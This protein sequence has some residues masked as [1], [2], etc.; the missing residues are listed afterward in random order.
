MVQL[1]KKILLTCLLTD[2]FHDV[3]TVKWGYGCEL[4]VEWIYENSIIHLNY[5][6]LAYSNSSV[7]FKYYDFWVDESHPTLWSPPPQN[8]T[9]AI[10]ESFA[11]NFTLLWGPVDQQHHLVYHLAAL[12]ENSNAT[13]HLWYKYIFKAEPVPIDFWITIS[14]ICGT[15][16]ILI[17]IRRR[18]S[19]KHSKLG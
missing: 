17:V 10:G 13:V 15:M 16:F 18:K 2:I 4:G 9:L 1:N 14:A 6:V 19:S 5:T 11:D 7:S 8:F 12:T 3:V